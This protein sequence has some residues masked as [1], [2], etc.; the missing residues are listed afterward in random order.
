M[1]NKKGYKDI[2][3]VS[4]NTFNFIDTSLHKF[5]NTDDFSV[6]HDPP[7]RQQWIQQI[8]RHQ[9]FD[10]TPISYPVCSLHFKS[11]EILRNGKR[12]ILKKGSVPTIFPK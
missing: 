2:F 10:D 5:K 6:P 11:D 3:Q 8:R 7:I 12:T 1:W 9:T 4:F